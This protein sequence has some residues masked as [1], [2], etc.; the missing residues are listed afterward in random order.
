MTS[1]ILEV[2]PANCVIRIQLSLSDFDPLTWCKQLPCWLSDCG[3]VAPWSCCQLGFRVYTIA[4][5]YPTY[6]TVDLYCRAA[7]QNIFGIGFSGTLV[8]NQMETWFNQ[9]KS[10]TNDHVFN[11]PALVQCL[12]AAFIY[13]VSLKTPVSEVISF[14]L[15]GFFSG[16]PCSYHVM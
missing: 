6:P 12:H 7:V 15:T 1:L 8:N 10:N 13:Q 3:L 16:A 14:S 4:W 9:C 11:V 5:Y 2:S